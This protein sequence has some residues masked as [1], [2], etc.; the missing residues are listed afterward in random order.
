MRF[1][2]PGARETHALNCRVRLRRSSSDDWSIFLPRLATTTKGDSSSHF[3]TLKKCPLAVRK[4]EA[5][6]LIVPKKCYRCQSIDWVS[7]VAN[8]QDSR[9]S[10]RD[11]D[12]LRSARMGQAT[13]SP[14]SSFFDDSQF[15][16]ATKSKLVLILGTT[17]GSKKHSDQMV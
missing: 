12:E 1:R 5:D 4:N 7:S 13:G 14:L 11:E 3:L 17:D 8:M 16:I 6:D 10:T 2:S 15:L 9:K